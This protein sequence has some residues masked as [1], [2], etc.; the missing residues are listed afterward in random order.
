MHVPVI[1]KG[2]DLPIHL[3]ASEQALIQDIK[4]L[5]A[6]F[7]SIDMVADEDSV[8]R[9]VSIGS[10]PGKSFPVLLPASPYGF[11]NSPME[12]YSDPDMGPANNQ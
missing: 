12:Y 11:V 10:C 6:Y 5:E 7:S 3:T 8:D 4:H 2:A 1:E 9:H